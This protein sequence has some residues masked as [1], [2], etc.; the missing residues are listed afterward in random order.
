MGVGRA[1]KLPAVSGIGSFAV[2]DDVHLGFETIQGKK[3]S[4][5]DSVDF[6]EE[7]GTPQRLAL[8]SNGHVEG[9]PH[10][11]ASCVN[12]PVLSGDRRGTVGALGILWFDRIWHVA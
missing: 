6:H 1:G 7:V 8:G 2:L 3:A 10:Q 5:H 12:G 9:L 11:Y 4:S